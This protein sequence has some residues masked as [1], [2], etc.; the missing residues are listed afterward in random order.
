MKTH[1]TVVTNIQRLC[2]QGHMHVSNFSAKKVMG[3]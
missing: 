1:Y 3:K 2:Q